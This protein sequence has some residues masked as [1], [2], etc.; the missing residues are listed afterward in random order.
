MPSHGLGWCCALLLFSGPVWGQSDRMG[1]PPAEWQPY[2]AA[3][4]AAESITHPVKRCRAYPDLPGNHW[5]TDATVYCVLQR[6]PTLSLDD[7]HRQLSAPGGAA[8]LDRHYQELLDA[9]YAD[10][11]QREQIFLAFQIFDH[12]DRARQIAD[13]WLSA[14]PDSAFSRLASGLQRVSAAW[15]ARGSKLAFNTKSEQFQRMRDLLQRAAPELIA[16]LERNPKLS[17]ACEGL[18]QVGQAGSLPELR[19]SSLAACLKVDPDSYSVVR[20]WIW[21]ARPKWGGSMEEMRMATAYAMARVSRNPLMGGLAASLPGYVAEIQAN[22]GNWRDALPAFEAADQ[23]A[24]DKDVLRQTAV[25]A[26]DAK[27]QWK[28]LAYVSQALR[29]SPN[30]DIALDLRARIRNSLGDFTGAIDDAESALEIRPDNGYY[31]LHLGDA[32]K[33]LHH[34]ELA[35]A[36]YRIARDDPETHVD[37]EMLWCTSFLFAEKDFPKAMDCTKQL[38]AEFPTSGEAWRMRMWILGKTHN[39]GYEK[40]VSKFMQYADKSNS[41]H[42]AVTR[43]I[44]AAR[45]AKMKSDANLPN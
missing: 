24:P 3:V 11:D 33:Y 21:S 14:A 23:V 29:F 1:S 15:E 35:R 18:M 43:K 34:T 4:H 6:P 13:E 9:H 38:V 32:H 22:E 27:D 10:P 7:I 26:R 8:F 37:G 5:Q 2:L 45:A 36:A 20:R 39:A 12:G 40:A 41:T 16:A 31:A 19:E 17:P 28:A 42:V 25:S 44:Q 30:D